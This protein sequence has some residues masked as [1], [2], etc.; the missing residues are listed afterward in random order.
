MHQKSSIWQEPPPTQTSQWGSSEEEG[1]ILGDALPS[2]EP[3][4]VHSTS[5]PAPSLQSA[6][7]SPHPAVG[8]QNPKL[9]D[10]DP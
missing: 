3:T 2:R 7:N 5:G 10:Q 1:K 8:L 9:Q 4:S 6:W